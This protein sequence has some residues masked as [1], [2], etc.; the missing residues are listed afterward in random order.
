MISGAIVRTWTGLSA[1]FQALEL[2]LDSLSILDTI[3]PRRGP[4]QRRFGWI[5][6]AKTGF[7][8]SAATIVVFTLAT[9]ILFDADR[10]LEEIPATRTSPEVIDAVQ[11]YLR[12]ATHRGFLN[13]DAP[14]SCWDVF[15]TEEFKVE[16]LLY[17]SWRVDAYY[18]LVRYYWRVDDKTM[19]VTRD[20]WFKTYNPTIHC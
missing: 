5:F 16:Y 1:R 11:E 6:A 7:Y 2:H 13:Q 15:E 12:T 3:A 19:E 17:G 20:A 4:K 10:T 14:A 9:F 8:A 18:R